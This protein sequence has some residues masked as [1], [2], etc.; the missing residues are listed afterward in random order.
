MLDAEQRQKLIEFADL[1]LSPYQIKS[2]GQ[3]D[4]LIPDLCP[5][6]H[7][8]SHGKDKHTFALFLN[9][10]TFVCKRGS[11][12]RH[13]RFE[14]LAKELTNEEVKLNRSAWSKKSE[15]QYVMPSVQVFDP[16]EEIYRYFESRKISR[17]TVDALKIGSD[18]EGNIVFRF[19]WNGEDV[20]HKFRK[21]RKPT[22]ED[23]GRKEWQ[24]SG[25][26]A[27]LYN[28][29]NVVFSQPLIITEGRSDQCGVCPLRLR[30]HRLDY[31]LLRLA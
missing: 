23:K 29:D 5:L 20:Y 25:T 3:D 12:G 21:P 2:S 11:C 1:Y 8:G 18:F 7:G 10:G 13:G 22:P 9:N 15:K 14:E 17:S 19:F 6:C 28:M 31:L 4:K 16:T 27:I 30:Q 24:E 26:R